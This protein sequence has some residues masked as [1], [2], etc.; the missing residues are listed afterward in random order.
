MAWGPGGVLLLTDSWPS[1]AFPNQAG[2]KTAQPRSATAGE[3]GRGEHLLRQTPTN[4]KHK[5]REGTGRCLCPAE[6][7]GRQ[8]PATLVQRTKQ[9]RAEQFI[10]HFGSPR[11][12]GVCLTSSTNSCMLLAM[13]LMNPSPFHV[14]F[15]LLQDPDSISCYQ[16]FLSQPSLLRQHWP[17]GF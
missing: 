6:Q 11:A 7:Q 12:V 2:T 8:Q 17:G 3:L 9:S 14:A 13:Q 16:A 4:A 1:M 10:K 15:L 5:A